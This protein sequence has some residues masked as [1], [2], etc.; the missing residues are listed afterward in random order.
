[1]A[2]QLTAPQGEP[3]YTIDIRQRVLL[4]WGLYIVGNGTFINGHNPENHN[5]YFYIGVK[6]NV[7]LN[8]VRNFQYQNLPL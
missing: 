8:Y 5:L 1:V 2:A 7:S 4:I 3:S 6:N